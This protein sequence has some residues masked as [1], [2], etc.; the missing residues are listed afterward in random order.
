MVYFNQQHH[1]PLERTA[2]ILKDLYGQIVS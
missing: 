1:V 2:E